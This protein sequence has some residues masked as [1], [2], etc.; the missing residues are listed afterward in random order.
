ML[1]GARVGS[2]RTLN[3][4]KTVIIAIALAVTSTL[5]ACSTPPSSSQHVSEQS[6]ER[7]SAD[8][9]QSLLDA[10]AA[11]KAGNLEQA[12]VLLKSGIADAQF[13]LLHPKHQ[14]YWLDLSS[15]VA[16]QLRDLDY[17]CSTAVRA[18][19][20]KYA[21]S[22]NWQMRFYCADRRHDLVDALHSL[23][24]VALSWP[25]SL[26]EANSRDVSGFVSRVI[27][28]DAPLDKQGLLEALFWAKW[29]HHKG[30]EPSRFWGELA[31]MYLEQGQLERAKQVAMRIT[32]PQIILAMRVDRRFEPLTLAL[33]GHF[34]VLIAVD[35]EVASLEQLSRAYPNK[36]V[37]KALHAQALVVAGRYDL[38]IDVTDKVLAGRG[39]NQ[40]PTQLYEDAEE[41]FAWI[42]N[43]RASALKGLARWS[44]AEKYLRAAINLAEQARPNVSQAINLADMYSSLGRSR[45]AVEQVRELAGHDD[46]MSPYAQ[47]LIQH[48]LLRAAVDNND[49]QAMRT[50]LEILRN[51]QDDS[52][53]TFQRA[54]LDANEMEEAAA[55]L[56]RRLRDPSLRTDALLDVQD[57]RL[58]MPTPSAQ[59]IRR[60]WSELRS[61]EDVRAAVAEVGRIEIVPLDFE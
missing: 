54:L 12:Q 37:P 7:A 41:Q 26:D 59:L 52:P 27:A 45:E 51:K 17:A 40:V 6:D 47:M 38:A 48:V 3:H 22:R 1:A 29:Q 57:Y 18:T 61:R 33:P 46:L 15:W 20:M 8:Y 28:S 32:A 35:K 53:K 4:M 36:L 10:L 25:D 14:H 49:A 2:V 21:S 5:A 34:D 13:G 56:I 58:A 24:T 19:D 16:F 43:A 55:V 11:N 50:A 31:R 30:I 39:T 9:K 42:L 44:E 60:R 23:K